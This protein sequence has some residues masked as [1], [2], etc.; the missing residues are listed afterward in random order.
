[1]VSWPCVTAPIIRIEAEV[2]LPRARTEA[3]S[4]SVREPLR[5]CRRLPVLRDRYQR[6]Q[7]DNEDLIPRL[8]EWAVRMEGEQHKLRSAPNCSIAAGDGA[9]A[10]GRTG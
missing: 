3:A 2:P 1:V 8:K 6:S 9:G 4:S 7:E 5:A 10:S